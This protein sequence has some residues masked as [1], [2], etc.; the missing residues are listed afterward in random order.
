MKLSRKAA[1]VCRQHWK[2]DSLGFPTRQCCHGCPAILKTACHSA[3]QD[4][5]GM[6]A[7]RERVN[8]AAL[9]CDLEG[10]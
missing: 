1:K 10:E 7:W 4:Y 3:P 2:Q 9:K 8:N 6:D 5:D